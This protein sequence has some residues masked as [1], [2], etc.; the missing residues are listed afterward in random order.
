MRLLIAPDSFK[1]TLSST[2][3]CQM[4]EEILGHSFSILAHPLAD[5]GEGTLEAIAG[6]LPQAQWITQKVMGPLPDQ[7][8]EAKYLWLPPNSNGFYRNGPGEWFNVIKAIRA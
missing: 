3:V 6:C 1:G 8:V 7:R 2:E 5:G 4:V